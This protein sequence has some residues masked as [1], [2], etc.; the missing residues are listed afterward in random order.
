MRLLVTGGNGFIATNFIKLALETHDIVSIDNM[1]YSGAGDN[2]TIYQNANN[3]KFIHEDIRNESLE[4][5]IYDYSIDVLINFAA[6]S[7]VDRSIHDD[8][9]F[10]STNINGTHNLLQICKKLIASNKLS[11]NFKFIQISTD[12]VYGSLDQVGEPFNENSV[13]KPSNPYSAS[14]AAADLICNSY[15]KTYDFPVIITR[16]SNNYGPYQFPEKLIPLSINHIQANKKIPIYGTGAQIRDWI[17]VDDHCRGILKV[18]NNGVIGEVYNFGA[19]QELPNIEVVRKIVNYLR[20]NDN[21]LDHVS[22]VKDRKGH[23]YRYAINS[24]KSCSLLEWD[25]QVNFDTGIYPTIEWY[26]ENEFWC[27]SRSEIL[28]N[29]ADY[30]ELYLSKK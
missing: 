14:K 22:F 7:H 6:Q 27:S 5:I 16:C 17:H 26:L 19:S 1:S 30:Q 2:H 8:S 28:T 9:E 4:N 25:P 24:K 13:L 29:N 10:L 11:N 21:Y 18:L 3:Y 15:F 12:E 20:P 23:D